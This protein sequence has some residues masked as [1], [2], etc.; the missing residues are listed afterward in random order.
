MPRYKVV[1]FGQCHA[2]ERQASVHFHDDEGEVI[3][4][5]GV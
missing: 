1:N 2:V 3:M 4:L 5:V